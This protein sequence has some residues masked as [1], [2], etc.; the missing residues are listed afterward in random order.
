MAFSPTGRRTS[1]TRLQQ[2]HNERDGVSNHR[3]LEC[4]S[5]YLFR[6]RS[7]KTSK[8]RTTVFCEGNPPVHHN[9]TENSNQRKVYCP[10]ISLME[11]TQAGPLHTEHQI[12]INWPS[13][14]LGFVSAK[15]TYLTQ[16][17]FSARGYLTKVWHL[18]KALI[19]WLRIIPLSRDIG[20]GQTCSWEYI[21]F[22]WTSVCFTETSI[23]R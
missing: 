20:G 9:A 11:P 22:Q 3:R 5:N 8:L 2:R 19:H 4:S 10:S 6:C 21:N 18:I 15:L 13:C 1:D 12:Y 7:K 14:L 23:W 16:V 17:W